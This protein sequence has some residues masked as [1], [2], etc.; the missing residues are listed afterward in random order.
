MCPELSPEPQSHDRLVHAT[1]PWLGEG[2]PFPLPAEEY[3]TPLEH[4][5]LGQMALNPEL[6][7]YV[8]QEESPSLRPHARHMLTVATAN[9]HTIRAQVNSHDGVYDGLRVDGVPVARR[10]GPDGS[11]YVLPN[12]ELRSQRLILRRDIML[13]PNK[14]WHHLVPPRL[15]VANRIATLFRNGTP[16]LTLG[17]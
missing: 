4:A 7:R 5:V 9:G 10:I 16:T 2:R 1:P 13:N 12:G 15:R 8:P 3:M 6:V 17:R 11:L 14:H